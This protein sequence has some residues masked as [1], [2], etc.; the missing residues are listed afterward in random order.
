MKNVK[1]FLAATTFVAF[2]SCK[3]Q[4]CVNSNPILN[5]SE[6]TSEAYKSALLKEVSAVKNIECILTDYQEKDGV[7]QL[8]ID[9][10][11]EKLCAK[12]IVAVIKPD[13]NIAKVIEHKGNGYLNSYLENLEFTLDTTSNN[14]IYQNVSGIVD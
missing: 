6:P 7:P 2:A 13:E 12:T 3:E 8:Y 5:A 1:L 4:E 10:S 11:G 9:I 14:F